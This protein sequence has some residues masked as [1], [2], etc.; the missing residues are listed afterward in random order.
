VAGLGERCVRVRAGPASV[1][2]FLYRPAMVDLPVD[3]T[4]VSLVDERTGLQRVCGPLPSQLTVCQTLQFVEDDRPERFLR[5]EIAG[6]PRSEQRGHI[7]RRISLHESE[8]NPI[9][10]DSRLR[11]GSIQQAPDTE[12]EARIVAFQA[13]GSRIA[14][15]YDGKDEMV[16]IDPL[17]RSA[18]RRT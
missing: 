17:D 16:V 18:R 6:A 1:S 12:L 5:G 14:V 3:E 9:L 11:G 10:A 7:A 2:S 13:S 4:Q 8:D 15:V